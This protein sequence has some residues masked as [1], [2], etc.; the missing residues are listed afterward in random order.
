M[1]FLSINNYTNIF[2]IRLLVYIQLPF[3]RFTIYYSPYAF[4]GVPNK[5]HH[6]DT[7]SE[8]PYLAFTQCITRKNDIQMFYFECAFQGVLNPTP[9][10]DSPQ[11]EWKEDLHKRCNISKNKL[12]TI[13]TQSL[14]LSS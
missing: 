5:K 8:P 13:K 14:H 6:C 11:L 10:M 12:A 1:N 2:I 3:N 9:L 4:E 7:K